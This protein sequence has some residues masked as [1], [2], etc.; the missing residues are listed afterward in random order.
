M[1]NVTIRARPKNSTGEFVVIENCR[2]K[3][4]ELVKIVLENVLSNR[5]LLSKL[6]IRATLRKGSG[7]KMGEYKPRKAHL[8]RTAGGRKELDVFSLEEEEG[9]R[10]HRTPRL[11]DGGGG[12]AGA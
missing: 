9:G 2:R 4:V 8:P 7:K 12:R 11:C 3:G 6:F 10:K 5:F 1:K